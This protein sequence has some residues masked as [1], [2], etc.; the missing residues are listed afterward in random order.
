MKRNLLKM[1]YEEVS[2]SIAIGG[3]YRHFRG[4]LYWLD[5]IAEH[6]NTGEAMVVYH[7]YDTGHKYVRPAEEWIGEV[8]HNNRMVQRFEPEN[9]VQCDLDNEANTR[10]I[11][12]SP[13]MHE[14]L[15]ECLDFIEDIICRNCAA[16]SLKLDAEG[17]R[18][19]IEELIARIDGEKANNG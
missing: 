10:L 14:D 9:F 16:C 1:A 18:D 7:D 5:D 19:A 6:S 17:L 2:D 15:T 13:K 11:A 3:L 4:K 8:K 12:D